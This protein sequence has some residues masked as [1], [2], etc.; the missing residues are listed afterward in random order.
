MNR[1]Y[2]LIG[3]STA[4]LVA[5]LLYFYGGSQVPPGQSPLQK[6][7]AQNVAGIKNAF[8]ASKGKV[9]VLVLLSP[10]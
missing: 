2:I 6:L 9:R 10:T 1:K 7:T 5:A 8:N 3:I 4:A